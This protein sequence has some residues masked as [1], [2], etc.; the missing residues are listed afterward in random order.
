M[1][2]PKNNRF[3]EARAS[4]GRPALYENPEDLWN[5][6][7]E[8]FNWVAANPLVDAEVLKDKLKHKLAARPRMRAMTISSLCLFLQIS[9]ETWRNYRKKKD[10]LGVTTRAEKVIWDQK[11]SGAAAG[12]L[13]SNIIARDLGLTDKQEI[14]TAIV[15]VLE[16]D[17]DL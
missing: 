6:C 4:H 16:G 15:T 5:D 8:Y 17:D 2:A 13:E 12:M 11:F 1:A 14:K 7:V 10:F 9:D 3:W